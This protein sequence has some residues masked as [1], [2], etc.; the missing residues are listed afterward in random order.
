MSL[1][2]TKNAKTERGPLSD[3]RLSVGDDNTL[4]LGQL[5]EDYVRNRPAAGN[6]AFHLKIDALI[7]PLSTVQKM[8]ATDI[9]KVF[10]KVFGSISQISTKPSPKMDE[11][12]RK[13][14]QENFLYRE[15]AR[16]FAAEGMAIFS[17]PSVERPSPDNFKLNDELHELA[18]RA[19]ADP[20]RDKGFLEYVQALSLKLRDKN[21]RWNSVN[22][23]TALYKLC[24][25]DAA[26]SNRVVATALGEQIIN[27][28][29]D[30]ADKQV[31]DGQSV[32]NLAK[33]A[34][35]L[36]NVVGRMS[37]KNPILEK[38]LF[39]ALGKAVEY[40]REKPN[41][42]FADKAFLFPIRE[43]ASR[44]LSDEGAAALCSYVA[45][46]NHLFSH[47]TYS[48]NLGTIAATFHA[49]NGISSWAFRPDSDAKLTLML[50]SLND[51]LHKASQKID[52]VAAGSIIY[53][54]KGIDVRKVS[55]QG[56]EEVAR[57]MRLVTTKL[58]ALPPP[59]ILNHA[60]VSS[61]VKGLTL[62]LEVSGG[63]I[64]HATSELM[65]ALEHR[66]P[67]TILSF[68][69]F[70]FACGALVTLRA[71][72]DTHPE[73]P[74]R[75]L[76]DVMLA[77]NDS[78]LRVHGGY[79]D[80]IAWQVSQQAFA[81][82][83][84]PMP[85]A[86]KHL[87]MNIEPHIE[88]FSRP[89]RSEARVTEW[90]RRHPGARIMPNRFYDG[91]ELDIMVEPNINIEV[92]GTFHRDPA[93]VIADRQRDEYLSSDSGPRFRVVRVRSDIQEEEFVMLLDEVLHGSERSNR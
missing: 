84:K 54:L 63:P 79:S 85:R 24:E 15:H 58:N 55:S 49:L 6:H 89:T 10:C 23:V 40:T 11:A 29:A 80:V 51:R 70:G 93:K 59:F 88:K 13:E 62:A 5:L 72:T 17:A 77:A 61:I 32:C 2:Q 31:F 1:P 50:R 46:L 27:K 9:H 67:S 45:K 73:L 39:G 19:Q 37:P 81:L 21:Q 22:I 92:D 74:T 66:M 25:L 87:L 60:A 76:R 53:G 35:S 3:Q 90:T 28:L 71:H 26:W 83:D 41:E 47:M 91:F 43:I 68:D 48:S 34:P 14:A 38:R 65:T 75:L 86:L 57:T 44:N 42:Q 30:I 82:Y 4:K 20:N 52:S 18:R 78:T 36:I 8:S 64:P 7:E 56:V 33:S 12:Q 16:K 69:D